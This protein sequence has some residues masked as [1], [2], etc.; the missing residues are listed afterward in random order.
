MLWG[1]VAAAGGL[2]VLSQMAPMPARDVVVVGTVVPGTDAGEAAA[3]KVAADKAAADKVVADKATAD[4]AAADKAAADRAAADQAASDKAAADKA[5]ADKAASDQASA[6]KAAADKAAADKA[7]AEKAATDK[8]A[9]DKAAADKAAADQAAAAKIAAIPPSASVE[10]PA[11]TVGD[12]GLPSPQAPAADG[13]VPSLTGLD[14]AL[15]VPEAEPSPVVAEPAPAKPEGPKDALLIPDQ[16]AGQTEPARLPFDQ[17]ELLTLCAPRPVLY[18]NAT[19]DKWANPTGQFDMLRA[20]DPVYRLVAG[21]GLGA[22][23]MPE[24]G[25][26]LDSRLGY[27]IREGKHSMTTPDWKVWLDYADKWLK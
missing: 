12:P 10:P 26:L 9:S 23:K 19:E 14:Q 24:V 4:R 11:G 20:A 22:E 8:T 15:S 1:I 17:H 7:A 18:S 6:D 27:Y 13:A 3:A 25:K 2:V 5:A 21:D 16:P